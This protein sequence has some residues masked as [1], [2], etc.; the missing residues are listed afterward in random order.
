MN[1]MIKGIAIGLFAM[2]AVIGGSANAIPT[3]TCDSAHVGAVRTEWVGDVAY[4]YECDGS[5]WQL[6]SKCGWV[7]TRWVCM[8]Q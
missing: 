6:V 2:G 5:G 8:N 7:G 3:A 4:K 1:M